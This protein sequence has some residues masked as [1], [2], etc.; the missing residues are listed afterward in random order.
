M[1]VDGDEFYDLERASGGRLGPDPVAA[2]AAGD[3]L[4]E[5]A[6]QLAEV[7]ADGAVDVAALDAPLPTPRNVFAIGLNYRTHAAETGQELPAA[8]MVFAKFTGCVT[9]PGAEIPLAS[10]ST[11][12]EA[13]LVV[14]IGRTARDVAADAAWDVVAGLTV[15]Q[16]VSD[17]D[18]QNAGARPQFS[19]A[20]SHDGYGPMG[21]W[22][23]STDL[24]DDRDALPIRCAVNGE[25]RQDD[26]TS[27]LI[28]D[29][30]TLVA[31]LSSM[32][33]LQPGDVIYT[34]TPSG[35]GL[36]TRNFLR[37]G[38]EVTTTIDG[39]GTLINRIA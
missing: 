10:D 5:V 4:H 16:D 1:L 17:R 34:G 27:N 25:V 28:F 39:I 22:I 33:T 6:A 9:A 38:D 3:V 35:V 12:Y 19:L 20:K 36:P 29:V 30:P 31:Y 8:P 21:P 37:T 7:D 13:E 15:G 26:N 24:L 18:L 14:V 11:D 23:V 2:I 32:V